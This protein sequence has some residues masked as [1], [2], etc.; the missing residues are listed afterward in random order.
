MQKRSSQHR[1]RRAEDQGCG[2]TPCPWCPE[3]SEDV[4][5]PELLADHDPVEIE[6]GLTKSGAIILGFFV[7][8][9][10]VFNLRRSYRLLYRVWEVLS[11]GRGELRPSGEED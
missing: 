3:G 10:T 8:V 7:I 1:H 9:V 4:P 2:T 6:V 11:D 5:G